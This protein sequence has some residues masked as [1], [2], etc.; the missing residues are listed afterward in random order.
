MTH[1]TVARWTMRLPIATLALLLALLGGCERGDI[2]A[3]DLSQRMDE[4]ELAR[5][6]ARESA[7][8]EQPLILKFG[9]DLRGT[10]QEDARQYL[11]FLDY[12]SRAT[13]YRFKLHFTPE[14]GSIVEEL[15]NGTVQLAAMGAGSYLQAHHRYGAIPLAR[16]LNGEGRA[17][18]RSVIVV[19]PEA[20]FETVAQLRGKRIAFGAQTSTQGHLIPRIVLR[21]YG[22][23][24][25]DLAEYEFTGSHMNCAQK[26]INGEADACG[27]QDTLGQTLAEQELVRILHLSDPF[28]SSGIVA[29]ASLPPEM[30]ERIT[31]ALVAFDPRGRHREGLHHWE[32]TEMP[33]GFIAASP[34]DYD[35][36]HYWSMEFGVIPHHEE[37]ATP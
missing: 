19:R 22:I 17:E 1:R 10:P 26:V 9:F 4:Q 2:E 30:V 33:N 24:L 11:P 34:G 18:Y 7:G 23:E 25:R 31:A 21:H 8:A 14:P 37:D 27:M 12:L 32:R 3:I 6:L 28:P 36:L 16:G 29:N 5:E 35:A 13:G 15:G 20:P